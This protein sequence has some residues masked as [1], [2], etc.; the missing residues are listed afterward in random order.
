MYPLGWQIW[1]T[2]EIDNR[3]WFTGNINPV[4]TPS[5]QALWSGLKILI[6]VPYVLN[7]EIVWVSD[8]N[9]WVCY[10]GWDFCHICCVLF[11]SVESLTPSCTWRT[12]GNDKTKNCLIII[13]F[14]N[15]Y[16]KTFTTQNNQVLLCLSVGILGFSAASLRV[17]LK[18]SSN[19]QFWNVSLIKVLYIA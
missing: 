1:W 11:A 12:K 3:I 18:Y 2:R 4:N 14:S 5:V 19:V 9:L 7:P 10:R 6:S 13:T 8:L 15:D 16:N 17:S